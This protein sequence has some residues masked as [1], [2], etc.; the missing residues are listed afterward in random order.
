METDIVEGK[1]LI[2]SPRH[3]KNCG[4]FVVYNEK[5]YRI[6]MAE[7]C[8]KGYKIMLEKNSTKERFCLSGEELKKVYGIISITGWMDI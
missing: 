7:G 1:K 6:T 3:F 4:D 2:L 5:I 8:G